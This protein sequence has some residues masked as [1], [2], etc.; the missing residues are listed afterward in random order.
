MDGGDRGVTLCQIRMIGKYFLMYKQISF[1]ALAIAAL[2]PFPI[3]LG[4][5]FADAEY[6]SFI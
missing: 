6:L 2:S 3:P 1:Q 4:P 5:L